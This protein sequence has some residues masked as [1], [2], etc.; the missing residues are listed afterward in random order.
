MISKLLFI[1]LN[2]SFPG[3]TTAVSRPSCRSFGQPG[4]LR[5]GRPAYY[6][7]NHQSR[8]RQYN[9]LRDMPIPKFASGHSILSSLTKGAL[10]G[11]VPNAA[12]QL[13]AGYQTHRADSCAHSGHVRLPVRNYRTVRAGSKMSDL[14]AT[15]LLY[16]R[17]IQDR[18]AAEMR[19]LLHESRGLSF[20]S[21]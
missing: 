12:P 4:V 7:K 15:D 19:P 8:Y 20:K 21:G 16:R 10:G 6:Y 5:S 11:D 3:R 13:E 14:P 2:V 18:V 9:G 1:L 17:H